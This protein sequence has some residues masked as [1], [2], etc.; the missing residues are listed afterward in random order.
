MVVLLVNLW[1]LVAGL[2]SLSKKVKKIKTVVA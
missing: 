1:E 2:P